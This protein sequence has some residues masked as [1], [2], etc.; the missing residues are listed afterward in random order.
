M[1]FRLIIVVHDLLLLLLDDVHVLMGFVGSVL[2]RAQLGWSNSS[3]WRRIWSWNVL[4][5]QLSLFACMLASPSLSPIAQAQLSALFPWLMDAEVVSD[6]ILGD[7]LHVHRLGWQQNSLG[8]ACLAI[9]EWF[10]VSMEFPLQKSIILSGG[11]D[12]SLSNRG[13]SFLFHY[14]PVHVNRPYGL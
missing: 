10:Y 11:V 13:P 3:E 6:R 12:S 2:L 4:V 8:V 9:V 7:G 14:L 1:F 5:H